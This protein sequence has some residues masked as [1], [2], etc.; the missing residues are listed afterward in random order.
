MT[1]KL[2]KTHLLLNSGNTIVRPA[3]LDT[4]NI[5]FF[6]TKNLSNTI[7]QSGQAVPDEDPS[8]TYEGVEGEYWD[9]CLEFTNIEKAKIFYSSLFNPNEE[10]AE[11]FNK[12]IKY[13]E[14]LKTPVYEFRR[15]GG[16][17]C[18]S[19]GDKR[20]SAFNAIMPDG[21]SI[22]QHYQCDVK[23]YDVGGTNWRLGKGKPPLDINKDLETEYLKLWIVWSKNNKHLIEELKQKAREHNNILSD[24]FASSMVNQAHALSVI[25]N[26]PSL[27]ED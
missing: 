12:L 19:K 13:A 5:G 1:D 14:G 23:G 18:S 16:Y 9:L 24:M 10:S 21:R 15:R 6:L 27:L 3:L 20:F 7:Y 8:N 2:V 4:G 22:E 17:E 26:N 25:L 11:K